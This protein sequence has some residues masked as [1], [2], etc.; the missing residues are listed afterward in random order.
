MLV[1]SQ[2][3]VDLALERVEPGLTKYAWI[4][5]R[6]HRCDV[7]VDAEFQRRFNGFYRVR[8]S[9]TWQA[10]YYSLMEQSKTR[11]TTFADALVT[12]DAECGRVEASFASKLVATLDPSQPVI[13]QHVLRNFGLRMPYAHEAN[14]VDEVVDLHAELRRRYDR[15][16][17]SDAG[18]A[19]CERFRLRFPSADI[20]DLKRVD[21]VLWQHRA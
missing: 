16:L 6:V 5:Q 14:R 13:D 1:L 7:S 19:I 17:D 15:L 3:E 10:P 20:G 11:R 2:A 21:L 9:A 18:R 8:R 4:M 12:L